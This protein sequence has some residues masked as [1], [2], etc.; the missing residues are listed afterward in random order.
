[1]A[2][3]RFFISRPNLNQAFLIIDNTDEIHHMRDVLRL[4]KNNEV[5]VFNDDGEEVRGK[6]IKIDSNEVASEVVA[7]KT[8]EKNIPEIILACAIPKKSKFEIIIEKAAELGVSE[9][10][11]LR[12][13]RT[14]IKLDQQRLDKKL[15]RYRSIAINASKQSKRATVPF[16]HSIINF[17]QAL[18]QLGG[19]SELIIP[20]LSGKRVTLL[21][22]FSNLK[23]PHRIAVLIGPEGDFTPKEYALARKQGALAVTLGDTILKVETAAICAV[24]CANVFFHST[25]KTE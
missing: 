7:F 8:V 12:T 13:K 2:K 24:S 6:I 21:E 18:R 14:E 5:D 22:S 4:K 19:S 23:S 15:S 11:P 20:S 1:M 3:H 25:A 10:I 9:I 17:E 16:I